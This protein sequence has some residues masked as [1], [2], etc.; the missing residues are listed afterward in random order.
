MVEP[1]QQTSYTVTVITREPTNQPC[2]HCGQRALLFNAQ[3]FTEPLRPIVT[4][5]KECIEQR[6]GGAELV[7]VKTVSPGLR[8]VWKTNRKR[9]SP[10]SL[11]KAR[12]VS[13]ERRLTRSS[14]EPGPPGGAS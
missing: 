9:R 7:Y 14:L 6:A 13:A 2:G 11:K 3:C 1:R 10:E 12:I 8:E 4:A 5:C